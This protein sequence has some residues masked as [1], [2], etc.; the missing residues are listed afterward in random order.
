MK[1]TKINKGKPKKVLVFLSLVWL[2]IPAFASVTKINANEVGVVYNEVRGGVQE[3][4]YGEGVHLKSIFE[5]IIPISTVNRETKMET[6]GQTSDGQYVIFEISLIYKIQAK[7]AGL[8]YRATGAA[9][10]S[11]E[12][13][14]TLVKQTLQKETIKYNIFDLLSE[15]LEVARAGFE[16]ELAVTVNTKYAITLI[17]VS[18]DDVD[19]GAE[20]EQIL[21][22][23]AKAEQEIEIARKA[24][25]AKLIAAE[26]DAE[27]QKLLAEAAAYAIEIQGAASGQ[28]ASAYIESVVALIDTMYAEL[29][30]T[31]TYPEVADLILG[32]VF[33]NVWD[34]KLPE[35]L[36]S[37]DL[38]AMIGALITGK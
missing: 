17:A 9:N 29:G 18:F 23:L 26:A 30:G 5:T 4:T 15:K 3:K 35:V 27:A 6:T 14:N 16:S 10:I 38:S 28:A 8:F 21:K 24:A 33:Y 32:V 36:T 20:V 1:T 31:M 25:E 11:G 13:M 37:D 7:D 19:G 34:G 12:A 22:D 2:L